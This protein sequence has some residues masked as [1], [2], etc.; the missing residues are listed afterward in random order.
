[1]DWRSCIRQAALP[2]AKAA[3][4]AAGSMIIPLAMAK[5]PVSIPWLTL[6][7]FL[8]LLGTFDGKRGVRFEPLASCSN[9][10]PA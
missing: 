6:G 9:S 7:G 8:I 2:A 4:V 1:M 3:S 5:T 10:W